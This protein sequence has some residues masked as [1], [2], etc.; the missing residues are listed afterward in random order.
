VTLVV[1]FQINTDSAQVAASQ[2]SLSATVASMI[3]AANSLSSRLA[4]VEN[5][6]K[7]THWM[8]PNIPVYYYGV[9][10]TYSQV[11]VA[12]YCCDASCWCCYLGVCVCVCAVLWL[13][14]QQRRQHVL[15]DEPE[16]LGRRRLHAG[17]HGK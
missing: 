10:S 1:P 11:M 7:N 15:G 3:D 8:N 4:R 5:G 14:L 2:T 12:L 13:V 17:Q 6:V 16:L 9:F